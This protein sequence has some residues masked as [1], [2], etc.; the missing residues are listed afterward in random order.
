M[1]KE[2]LEHCLGLAV[3]ER[4]SLSNTGEYRVYPETQAA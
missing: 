4:L 3:L 1:K 2:R